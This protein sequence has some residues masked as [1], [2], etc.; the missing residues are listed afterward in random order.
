M[1]RGIAGLELIMK[2]LIL[3]LILTMA[4]ICH[5]ANPSYGNFVT[6]GFNSNNFNIYLGPGQT[7]EMGN[8]GTNAF[9]NLIGS[10]TNTFVR[11]N[12]GRTLFFSGVLNASNTVNVS[13]LA[14]ISNNI[15]VITV[16]TS[17]VGAAGA[18]I[19]VAS[20]PRNDHD[21]VVA[22]TCTASVAANLPLFTVQYGTA[23]SANFVPIWSIITQTNAVNAGV[24]QTRVDMTTITTSGF[25]YVSGANLT[26]L[27]GFTNTIHFL[28]PQ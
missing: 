24:F 22:F 6:G 21:F 2:N 28:V 3:F 14:F 4:G 7:N 12:D 15:P 20:F 27:N 17:G 11:T 19:L 5:A 8:Q 18:A 10:S 25:T 1:E 23:K 13:S 16:N 26:G 9:N